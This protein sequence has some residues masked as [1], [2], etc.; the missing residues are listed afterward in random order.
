MTDGHLPSDGS[1]M[2]APERYKME[3]A[4]KKV[5]TK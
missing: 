2:L 3:K 4:G 5:A 1:A